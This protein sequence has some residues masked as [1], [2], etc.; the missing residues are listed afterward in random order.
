MMPLAPPLRRP[1][2]RV[3]LSLS[4]SDFLL[5][6]LATLRHIVYVG[7]ELLVQGLPQ[8]MKKCSLILVTVSKG[9]LGRAKLTLLT[10]LS[11]ESLEPHAYSSGR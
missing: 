1:V 3:R 5:D 9:A 11:V 6:L 7:F 10:Y 4:R 8:S 2:L